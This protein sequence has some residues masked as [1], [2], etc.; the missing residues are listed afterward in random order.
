MEDS[1]PAADWEDLESGRGKKDLLLT[2]AHP[3][4]AFPQVAAFRHPIAVTSPAPSAGVRL[5]VSVV[6]PV[7]SAA[8]RPVVLLGDL[9]VVDRKVA[10]PVA[11]AA[12]QLAASAVA[13]QVDLGR[14]AGSAGRQVVSVG[15]RAGSVE[16]LPVVDS[17]VVLRAA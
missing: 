14:R 13:L 17:V 8:V 11:S 5:A 16:D 6:R 7:A 1:P 10:P 4:A 15:H 12:V 3:A 2:V 9:P